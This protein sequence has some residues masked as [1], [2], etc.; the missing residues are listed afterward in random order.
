MGANMWSASRANGGAGPELR[1]G[2]GQFATRQRWMMRSRAG[3]LGL[4]RSSKLYPCRRP[5][6]PASRGAPGDITTAIAA[7]KD[8]EAASAAR[9][10]SAPS[11]GRIGGPPSGSTTSPPQDIGTAPGSRGD[12]D[13]RDVGDAATRG[14][15][16]EA[17]VIDILITKLATERA[18]RN[19]RS[20]VRFSRRRPW[21]WTHRAEAIYSR[22]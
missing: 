21:G 20:S 14:D 2:R 9:C 15:P 13:P 16:D 1:A 4:C 5:P 17:Q 18:A 8:P 3:A 10:S 11:S 6:R 22:Q 19:A 12:G 7:L